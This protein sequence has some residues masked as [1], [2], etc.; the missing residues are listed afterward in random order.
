[1]KRMAVAR[2][3]LLHAQRAGAVRRANHDDIAKVA[4]DQLDAAEHER[5]H[6]DVAQLGIGLNQGEQLFAIELDHLARLGGAR[7]RHARRPVIIDAF[8]RELTRPV[9]DDERLRQRRTHLELAAHDDEER[10]GLGR[11][12][13][14]APRRGRSGGAARGPRCA[15]FAPPSTS[16]TAVRWE[17][18]RWAAT[19]GVSGPFT[20]HSTKQ[21]PAPRLHGRHDGCTGS[22]MPPSQARPVPAQARAPDPRTRRRGTACWSRTSDG[23][24]SRSG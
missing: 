21:R 8:A 3:K 7:R 11:R 10:Y 18:A 24:S 22:P 12:P 14:P 23:T 20:G 9:R 5:P 6:E 17:R 16:G 4:G 15:R 1:M 19:A 13:R 2:Q